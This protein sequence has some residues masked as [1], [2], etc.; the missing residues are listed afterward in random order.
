M[1]ENDKA[2]HISHDSYYEGIGLQVILGFKVRTICLWL[3]HTGI[4]ILM[5]SRLSFPDCKRD[6]SKDQE[7]QNTD[8]YQK[9]LKN[10]I[11]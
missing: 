5:G 6:N 10:K 9:C 4:F 11:F 7:H 1:E 3:G 8:F 2:Y